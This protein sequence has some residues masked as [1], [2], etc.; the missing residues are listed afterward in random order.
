MFLQSTLINNSAKIRTKARF[1]LDL[2]YS[3]FDLQASF[4]SCIYLLSCDIYCFASEIPLP[5][6][7]N[8]TG[9][10]YS[11]NRNC[12]S[13]FFKSGPSDVRGV[14]KIIAEK[15]YKFLNFYSIETKFDT[16]KL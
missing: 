12:L 2:G 6:E 1:P 3:M 15:C 4:P 9:P 16:Y 14:I 7:I 10:C 13:Q 11:N 8:H 5:E